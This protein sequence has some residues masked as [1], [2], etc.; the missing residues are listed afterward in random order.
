MGMAKA[1]EDACASIGQNAEH[2]IQMRDRLI[3]GLSEI[4]HSILNGDADK[5]LPGNV[6]FCFEGIEG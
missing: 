2:L 5:R 3:Q 6:H 4:P 1:L